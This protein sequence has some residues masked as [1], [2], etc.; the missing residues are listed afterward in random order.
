MR[1]GA[2]CDLLP[3]AKPIS[4]FAT[5]LLL[6]AHFRASGIDLAQIGRPPTATGSSPWPPTSRRLAAS[7]A[8]PGAAIGVFAISAWSRSNERRGKRAERES[9]HLWRDHRAEHRP[10]RN[11]SGFDNGFR[12]PRRRGGRSL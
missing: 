11:R 4:L 8:T 3:A 7:P 2:A 9:S 5:R 1:R 12:R 6:F 10:K